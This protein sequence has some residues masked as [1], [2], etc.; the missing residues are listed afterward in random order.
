MYYLPGSTNSVFFLKYRKFVF[1]KDK[2]FAESF[3]LMIFHESCPL[4]IFWCVFNAFVAMSSNER[5]GVCELA[6]YF[7]PLMM[8]KL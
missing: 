6:H 5:H 2:I 4:I 1:V 3:D 7:F 8:K